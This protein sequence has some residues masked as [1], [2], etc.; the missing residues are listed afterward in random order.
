VTDVHC[1]GWQRLC[2][3][4]WE[5]LEA[6]NDELRFCHACQLAVHRVTSQPELERMAALGK[7]VALLGDG[8]AP[9]VGRPASAQ[10]WIPVDD[11]APAD[12]DSRARAVRVQPVDGT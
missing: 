2:D 4:Q 3:R 9:K 10:Y 12:R 7:C 1:A 8:V 5:Q 6:I 11:E